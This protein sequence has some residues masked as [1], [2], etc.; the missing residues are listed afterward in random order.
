MPTGSMAGDRATET[1]HAVLVDKCND[2]ALNTLIV[3]VFALAFYNEKHMS[4]G[5]AQNIDFWK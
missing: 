2:S 3:I 1:S 5:P 4:E